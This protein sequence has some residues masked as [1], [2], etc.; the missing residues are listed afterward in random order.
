VKAN[1]AELPTWPTNLFQLRSGNHPANRIIYDK[2]VE[3]TG[4]T[5]SQDIQWLEF[6]LHSQLL[7]LQQ[8]GALRISKKYCWMTIS[9]PDVLRAKI[10]NAA[11]TRDIPKLLSELV[12]LICHSTPNAYAEPLWKSLC[13]TLRE[14]IQNDLLPFLAIAD[15]SFLREN[16]YVRTS[17]NILHKDS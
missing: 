16:V 10:R 3:L 13:L 2:D 4:L 8:I 12:V 7:W 1:D 5:L 11:T 15:D 6:V 9:M 17:P 14:P